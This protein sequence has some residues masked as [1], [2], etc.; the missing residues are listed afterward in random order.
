MSRKKNGFV[1][2]QKTKA[3]SDK[4]PFTHIKK[5]V[6]REIKPILSEIKSRKKGDPIR[7][8]LIN[9][10][11]IRSV[12]IMEYYLLNECA[13]FSDKFKDKASE[14]FK[15][16]RFDKSLGDQVISNYSFSNVEQFDDVFSTLLD[17]NFLEEVK[18]TSEEYYSYYYLEEEHIPNTRVLHKN[19]ENFLKIFEMRHEIIHHNKLYNL[20]YSEIR[21]F[22]GQSIQFTLCALLLF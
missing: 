6:P 2:E 1:S 17:I 3:R 14:L 21:D 22:V 4:T 13:Q 7:T 10:L 18:K 20:K 9:Y 19:W 8:G 12:S 11:I 15:S 16:V 5:F